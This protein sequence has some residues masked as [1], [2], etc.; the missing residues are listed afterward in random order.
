[1]VMKSNKNFPIKVSRSILVI[2]FIAIFT[3]NYICQLTN[4]D[5]IEFVRTLWNKSNKLQIIA[6]LGCKGKGNLEPDAS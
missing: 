2:K 4:V 5:W 6:V 1:M 3:K